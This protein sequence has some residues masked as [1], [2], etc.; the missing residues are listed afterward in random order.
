M[1]SKQSKQSKAL[2]K[3]HLARGLT[4]FRSRSPEVDR[5]FKKG[6]K[7]REEFR[8]AMRGIL[9]TKQKK[10]F[11]RM[12]RQA[13]LLRVRLHFQRIRFLKEMMNAPKK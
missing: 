8:E 7:I 13:N 10:I 4:F 5:F 1:A 9:N 6:M 11:N 12:V 2:L 3:K